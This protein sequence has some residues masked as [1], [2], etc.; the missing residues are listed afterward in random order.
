MG[1]VAVIAHISPIPIAGETIKASANV[2]VSDPCFEPDVLIRFVVEDW[3]DRIS[4]YSWYESHGAPEA[5]LYA[6]RAGST[7]LPWDSEVIAV[8]SV[9]SGERFLIHMSEVQ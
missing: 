8:R 7:G 4:G 5:L 2:T 9:D 1:G 6:W 3:W